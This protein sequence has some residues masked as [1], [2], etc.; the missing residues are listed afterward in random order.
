[1]AEQRLVTLYSVWGPTLNI[2]RLLARERPKGRYSTWR[3]GDTEYG[4][5]AI[6]SGLSMIVGG[7]AS[8]EAHCRTAARFLDR[9]AQF[10]RAVRSVTGP[11]DRSEL[12]TTFFV[13]Y[14]PAAGVQTQQ[15]SL[16]ATLLL[17]AAKRSVQWSMCV[18]QEASPGAP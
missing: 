7:G 15:I 6:T 4:S 5:A 2:D 17:L 10:I 11:R 18:R 3:R 1:M 9:E 14:P 12:S 16:P 8:S 13:E